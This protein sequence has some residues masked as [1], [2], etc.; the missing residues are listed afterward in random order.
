MRHHS[1][2]IMPEKLQKISRHRLQAA[3]FYWL[4][5]PGL[6]LGTGLAIDHLIGLRPWGHGPL[7]TGGILLILVTGIALISWSEHD[8]SR[9]GH[10]SPSPAQPTRRLV[11]SGS[12]HLC[13][14]PMFLGYDLAALAISLLSGSRATPLISFPLMLLW[15]IRFLRREE[16]ILAQRFRQ[17]YPD[18]QAKTPFLIPLLSAS[19]R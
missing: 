14:H 10:G 17:D 7:V 11:V 4:W 15:Q 6:V 5:L 1:N 9:L 16:R 18:Y 3:L 12:Y 8:L 13:R 2:I 19:R